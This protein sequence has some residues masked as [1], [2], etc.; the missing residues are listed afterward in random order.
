MLAVAYQFIKMGGEEG[1]SPER[2]QAFAASPAHEGVKS[3][4]CQIGT[5]YESKDTRTHTCTLYTHKHTHTHTHTHAHTHTQHTPGDAHTILV[6]R[7]PS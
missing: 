5:N 6:G 3:V 4:T 7:A 2:N 1:M